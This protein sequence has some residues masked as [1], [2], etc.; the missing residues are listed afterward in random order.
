MKNMLPK[1]DLEAVHRQD[2]RILLENWGLFDD[3]EAGKIKCQFCNDVISAHNFGAIF[4]EDKQIFF[5]CPKLNCLAKLS[6]QK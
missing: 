3:F 5:A 6:K 4:S 1:K 2:I